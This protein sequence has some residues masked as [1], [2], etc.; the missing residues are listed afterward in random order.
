[1]RGSNGRFAASKPLDAQ[2]PLWRWFWIGSSALRRGCSLR[3]FAELGE[4]NGST[5][6]EVRPHACA[7]TFHSWSCFE[8]VYASV[9]VRTTVWPLI[10]TLRVPAMTAYAKEPSTF[11]N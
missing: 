2:R 1:M 8:N 4:P 3:F 9:P 10:V 11:Q 5:V 6:Y 7:S